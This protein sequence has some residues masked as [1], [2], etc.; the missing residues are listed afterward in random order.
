MCVEGIKERDAASQFLM[1]NALWPIALICAVYDTEEHVA[2]DNHDHHLVHMQV[3]V[4]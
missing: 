1:C 4:F 2:S 3:L